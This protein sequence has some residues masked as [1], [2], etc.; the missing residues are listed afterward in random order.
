MS[1]RLE[2]LYGYEEGIREKLLSLSLLNL[3]CRYAGALGAP[4][5]RFVRQRSK[6]ELELRRTHF[7]LEQE[8]NNDRIAR[9]VQQFDWIKRLPE[10]S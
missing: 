10:I 3:A 6:V 8:V 1:H 7:P 4:A 5:Y 9:Q 2:P